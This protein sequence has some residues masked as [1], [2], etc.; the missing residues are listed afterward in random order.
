MAKLFDYDHEMSKLSD[1]E[2]KQISP[3]K[4]NSFV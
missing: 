2:D 4:R 1:K 3:D